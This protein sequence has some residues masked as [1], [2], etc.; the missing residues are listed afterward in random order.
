MHLFHCFT[1][2]FAAD[3][4]SISIMRGT[5]FFES[6]WQP[7]DESYAS[8]IEDEHLREFHGQKIPN[9]PPVIL[10]GQKKGKTHVKVF[11][12]N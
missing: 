12:K 10:K 9:G 8:E 7:V 2:L 3:N 11:S 5:W 4:T 6:T 1:L